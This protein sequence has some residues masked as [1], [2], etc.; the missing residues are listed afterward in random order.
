MVVFTADERRVEVVFSP[1][2]VC[3]HRAFYSKQSLTEPPSLFEMQ[4]IQ[5]SIKVEFWK[6]HLLISS[7][8]FTVQSRLNFIDADSSFHVGKFHVMDSL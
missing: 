7:L 2:S 5:D 1:L 4:V 3:L 6:K 8:F